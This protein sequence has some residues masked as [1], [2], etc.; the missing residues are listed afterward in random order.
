MTLNIAIFSIEFPPRIFGGL[1]SYV[2]NISREFI[3]LDNKVIVFTPNEEYKLKPKEKW[4]RIKVYR[5][6]AIS[7]RDALDIFLS[8]ETKKLWGPHGIDFLLSLLSYNHLSASILI[9]R[10]N[11]LIKQKGISI[12]LCVGHDWLGLPA[13]MTVKRETNI[14]TIYHVHSTESGRSLGNI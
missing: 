9:N 4:N 14:P 3:K 8:N 11:K 1:G 5:P 12:D 2:I 7:E 10:F 6:N 13:L